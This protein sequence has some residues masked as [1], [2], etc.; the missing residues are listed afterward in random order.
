MKPVFFPEHTKVLNKPESMTDHECSPLHVYTH[1]EYCLSC[2]ELSDDEI[3]ELIKTKKLWL[4]IFSGSTQPPIS[5]SVE[6]PF[7]SD[8]DR[9]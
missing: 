3:Q 2:W 9:G 7:K 6:H 5:A 4:W 8:I 1:G